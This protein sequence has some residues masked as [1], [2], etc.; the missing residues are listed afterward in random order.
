MTSRGNVGSDDIM[1]A[2]CNLC[3]LR[4]LWIKDGFSYQH[5]LMA[6]MDIYL[7]A[8]I[9]KRAGEFFSKDYFFAFGCVG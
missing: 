7:G 9:D 4:N 5:E 2:H 3:N 6:G 8:N 1:P